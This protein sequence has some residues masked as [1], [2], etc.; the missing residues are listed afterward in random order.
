MVL[1][2]S[3]AVTIARRWYC[4]VW[5]VRP[6]TSEYRPDEDIILCVRIMLRSSQRDQQYFRILPPFAPSLSLCDI[7]EVYHAGTKL[8]RAPAKKAWASAGQA[9]IRDG[10]AIT[11]LVPLDAVCERPADPAERLGHYT[12]RVNTSLLKPPVMALQAEVFTVSLHPAPPVSLKGVPNRMQQIEWLLN[13]G[14]QRPEGTLSLLRDVVESKNSVLLWRLLLNCR[15]A[16]AVTKLL[17]AP[18]PRKMLNNE[19]LMDLAMAT[20][21]VTIRRAALK[22]LGRVGK[23]RAIA[24]WVEELLRSQPDKVTHEIGETVFDS[25]CGEEDKPRKEQPKHE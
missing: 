10:E 9:A 18:L 2:G 1:E 5:R 7:L 12:V 3:E 13:S 24:L 22:A 25:L 17:D 15:D 19:R 20:K 16:Y 23:D 11:L 6:T 4:R 21:D 14:T 8:P